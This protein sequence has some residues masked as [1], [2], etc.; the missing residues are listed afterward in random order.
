MSEVKDE[1]DVESHGKEVKS[2]IDEEWKASSFRS[3]VTND[4]LATWRAMYSIPS[5]V[6]MIIPNFSDRVNDPSNG[7]TALNTAILST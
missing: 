6:E 4:M 5:L 1:E 3:M 7:C 2:P